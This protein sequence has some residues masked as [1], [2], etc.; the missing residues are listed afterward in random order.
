LSANYGFKIDIAW[1]PAPKPVFDR[2]H[3]TQAIK[4]L[5][6]QILQAM[7]SGC[8]KP[9]FVDFN[10]GVTYLAFDRLARHLRG[11]GWEQLFAHQIHAHIEEVIAKAGGA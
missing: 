4:E 11:V 2:W 3:E 1:A 7:N 10:E 6:T 5:Q 9:S 8:A